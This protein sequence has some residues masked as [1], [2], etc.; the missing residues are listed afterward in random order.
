MYIYI[1]I[2]TYYVIRIFR[3][4]LYKHITHEIVFLKIP[5]IWKLLILISL[6]NPQNKDLLFTG[7]SNFIRYMYI[8][9][10]MCIGLQIDEAFI[11]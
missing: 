9:R 5:L 10:N 6:V 8:F 4:T 2:H 1:Y 7:F 3:I 11:F